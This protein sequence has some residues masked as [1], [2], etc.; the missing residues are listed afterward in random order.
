MDSLVI[1]DTNISVASK[2]RPSNLG[3]SPP[4]CSIL[5]QT[6]W[7][8]LALSIG[9]LFISIEEIRPISKFSEKLIEN[10]LRI[11]TEVTHL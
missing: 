2:W 3:A 10:K 8:L 11:N 1:L 5:T 9:L 6:S 7:P 4:T